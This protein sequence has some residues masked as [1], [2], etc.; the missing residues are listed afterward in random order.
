MISSARKFL[1][2]LTGD[3]LQNFQ[4]PTPRAVSSFHSEVIPH[5]SGKL[6]SGGA[7]AGAAIR[8]VHGRCAKLA[9]D[10]EAFSQMAMTMRRIKKALATGMTEAERARMIWRTTGDSERLKRGQQLEKLE[11]EI[12]CEV[13]TAEK[14]VCICEVS[15]WRSQ[16][17]VPS[18]GDIG[19]NTAQD[20]G[21]DTRRAQEQLG[22]G[23]RGAGAT[24]RR[25]FMR[26]KRRTTRKVRMRRMTLMGMSTGPRAT[27]ERV[28]TRKSK[29]DQPS[30]QKGQSQ[31]AYMLTSS[32]S[33]KSAVNMVSMPSRTVERRC[34][35]ADGGLR[36]DG[37]R[38]SLYCVATALTTKF[39][40]GGGGGSGGGAARGQE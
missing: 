29:T 26:P 13:K 30:R 4:R 1:A 33:V 36:V 15:A 5:K 23:Q 40:G 3:K 2:T 28:M 16:Q 39:C 31:C 18:L 12:G 10:Q 35:N 38:T 25:A 20:F 21:S 9:N 8:R 22:M 14:S 19:Q 6:N 24:W 34:T 32:S 7:G 27:R 17:F 37:L 11:R